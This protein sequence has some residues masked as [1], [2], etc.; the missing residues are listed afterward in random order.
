MV[1]ENG[2]V[3]E[4][5]SCGSQVP[6]GAGYC[7]SCGARQHGGASRLD[8]RKLATVVFADLVGS[9]ALADAEDPERTRATL[10]R[11]YEA[12]ADEIARAGGVVEKFA[13]DAV[14]AAFGAP[15]AL[16]DHAERALHAALAMHRRL[17]ALFDG[18]LS[19]RVGVN[20]GE[21]VV[22]RPREGSS[23]VSGDTVNVA[24]RL[25]QGAAPGETLVGRR[26]ADLA[27]GAFEFGEPRRVAAKGKA[28]PVLGVPVVRALRLVRPRGVGTFPAALVGRDAELDLLVATYAH[29]VEYGSAHLVTIVG[30]AGLGKTRLVEELWQRLEATSPKPAR[31][32]GRCLAYGHGITYRPLGEVLREHLGLSDGDPPEAVRT[33]LGEREML[34]LALGLEVPPGLHP[35]AARDRHHD[36]WV[37]L[38]S[39]AISQRPL[40]MVIEDLHW[41]EEPLLELLARFARDVE[42]PLLVVA[43]ARP[44]LLE[45]RPAWG[46]GARNMSQIWL[47]P[48]TGAQVGELV[49]ALTRAD[50]PDSTIARL[51]ERAEGNPF[52]AEE[53]LAAL[54][55]R[56]ML[57]QDGE[58][59]QVAGSPGGL[60]LPD[61]VQAVVA[62]RTDLLP[63]AEKAALQ[64]GAV[65]GRTF[66]EGAVVELL[67]GAK[68]D[69]QLLEARDFIRQSR[70]SAFAEQ[71][72]FS[73]KHAVTRE[74][75]YATVAKAQRARL[76]AAF[77]GWLERAGGGRDEHASLLAHHYARSVEPDA[78]D[79]AWPGEPETITRLRA[80]AAV[81]LRRAG[82]LAVSRYELDDGIALLRQAVEFTP[83][84]SDQAELWREIGR[85]Y[86]L[87]FRGDEFL[88]AMERSLALS[89]DPRVRAATYAELGY[90]MSFRA[91]MW[92]KAP[93]PDAVA[94]WIEHALVLTD[95][96][97]SARCKALIA[98]CF[99]SPSEEEDAAREAAAIAE[100]LGE[101][102]LRAAAFDAASR[103]AY[104]AGRH[105]EAL[106]LARRPLE[107]MD[108]LRDPE[109]VIE[110]Y[111]T[112]IPVQAMLGH[113]DDAREIS[114]LHAAVTERLTPHH[115]LHGVSV[116]AELEELCAGWTALRDLTPRIERAVAAN[117]HTPCSRNQRT[118][119][120]CAV[121][122]RALGEAGEADR[123]EEAAESHAMEGYDLQ[124]SGPRLR[125]AL[126]KG[127]IDALERNV[128]AATAVMSRDLYWW[129]IAARVAR[130]DA[131]VQLGDRDRVEAE[132]APLLAHERT[133]VEPFALRALGEVRGD[134]SLVERALERFGCL[135]LAWHAQQTRTLLEG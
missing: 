11:F 108:A 112:V 50:M 39:E 78:V 71:R 54:V 110:A 47:E 15:I 43:T 113:F 79:L 121:A 95:P 97:T 56:Q 92:T 45:A 134:R 94:S 57:V 99:W 64:A 4:C 2:L 115:R 126:L 98:R 24:A 74:V 41:A 20:T 46:G 6:A 61:T 127:D 77:A 1:G 123:L 29:A 33:R 133:Y 65:V 80:R 58:R 67:Q 128:D 111:E 130:L 30:D 105:E 68:P 37:E 17:D 104:R 26:T 23:F 19:L 16:E 131:L 14:M 85:G 119:L 21:L 101:P 35:M 52:F 22:G 122:H 55:D 51:A 135:G 9:T 81:W 53:L 13:G 120:V 106:A 69:F 89:A 60:D 87:G 129:S 66:W 18:R 102:D 103:V 72:E 7:P 3:T 28:R 27:R 90:Q 109:Q 59:W 34:G 48:L 116:R 100:T 114:T 132:A 10:E 75:A 5:A 70:D 42:G 73:F 32:T 125:L 62:A 8:E 93:D 83:D 86:A 117:L 82:T 38:L 124:F 88:D 76:H 12:M 91:G 25:E 84:E 40:V 49:R 36:A 118:L 31:R 44:Q 107:F 96:Q 63:P